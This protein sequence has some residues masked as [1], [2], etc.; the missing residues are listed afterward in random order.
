MQQH[1]FT[2]VERISKMMDLHWNSWR[3]LLKVDWKLKTPKVAT[4]MLQSNRYCRCHQRLIDVSSHSYAK[5]G[6]RLWFGKLLLL[7]E[8]RHSKQF[9]RLPRPCWNVFLFLFPRWDMLVVW[10]VSLQDADVLMWSKV[11][12]RIVW[13]DVRLMNVLHHMQHLQTNKSCKHMR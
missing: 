12:S 9:Y 13:M 4:G 6:D 1:N 3:Y 10:R 7:K 11:I 8:S 5:N 2:Q